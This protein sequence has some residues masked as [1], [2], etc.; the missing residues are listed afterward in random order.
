M[1]M[2]LRGVETTE[3]RHGSGLDH[4]ELV[5]S[6]TTTLDRTGNR[7]VWGSHKHVLPF[8]RYICDSEG[9]TGSPGGVGE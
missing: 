8:P 3:V 5:P 1:A 4:P 9:D 2:S 7:G 6:L